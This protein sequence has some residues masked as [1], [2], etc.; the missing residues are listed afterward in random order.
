MN[1]RKREEEEEE[2]EK[3]KKKKGG[4]EKTKKKHK[5]RSR[6]AKEEEQ[7]EVAYTPG[8]K[9]GLWFGIS[10][11]L[12]RVS[13]TESFHAASTNSHTFSTF[14]A[15]AAIF[16]SHT[17]DR[18][19]MQMSLGVLGGGGGARFSERATMLLSTVP[20]YIES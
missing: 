14:N 13:T 12:E 20:L 2:E 4:N 6:G 7:Q 15:E 5:R 1:K 16:F 8:S 3:K 11:Y 17:K 9:S 10:M 19:T 18:H